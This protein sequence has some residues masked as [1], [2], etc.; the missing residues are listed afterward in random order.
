G[1]VAADVAVVTEQDILGDRLVRAAKRKRRAE[2]FLIEASS[3]T[4]GD[5]VVHI[6]HGIGRY[7]GLARIEVAGAPHDCLRVLYADNDKLFVPVENIDVLSRY[8]SEEAG[9]QLDKLGGIQ[10]QQRKARAK[11]RINEIADQ[12]MKIAAERK[13]R[14]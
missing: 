12:L 6:D 1:F 13:L 10:W 9:A 8:G 5:L 7:D 14:P 2:N 4:E 11:Q 3:L